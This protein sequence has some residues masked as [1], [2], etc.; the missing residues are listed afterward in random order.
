MSG[1]VIK[2][3]YSGKYVTPPGSVHSYVK[4]LENARVYPTRDA[5]V[6][7]SCED[8]TVIPL[9]EIFQPNRR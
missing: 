2:N 9:D 5:A 8:E 7:D 4:S 6:A 3:N 1:Y